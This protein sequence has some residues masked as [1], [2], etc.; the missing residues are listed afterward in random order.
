[1]GAAQ[2]SP[3]E[4]GSADTPTRPAG[5]LFAALS[6]RLGEGPSQATSLGLLD[7]NDVDRRLMRALMRG[8]SQ[9]RSELS[10]AL[11][12]TVEV[13]EQALAALGERPKATPV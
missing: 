13:I 6:D 2:D 12:E 3:D 7:L 11:A 5:G 4:T 8:G 1:M 9:S 10:G